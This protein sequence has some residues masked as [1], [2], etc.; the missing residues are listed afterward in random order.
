MKKSNQFCSFGLF[1]VLLKMSS[2]ICITTS[3]PLT[4]KINKHQRFLLL[5]FV[6]VKN[7]PTTP[8]SV[9]FKAAAQGEFEALGI[10]GPVLFNHTCCQGNQDCLSI[11][12][13]EDCNYKNVF[14]L[15]YNIKTL[16]GKYLSWSTMIVDGN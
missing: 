7:R 12:L 16:D 8:D 14:Q 9:Y 5:W 3:Y 2:K 1:P 11:N 4:N 13:S 15:H 10:I 6:L